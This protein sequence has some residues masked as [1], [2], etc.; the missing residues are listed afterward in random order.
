M[1]PL[2]I[3]SIQTHGDMNDGY[4]SWASS[5]LEVQHN[6]DNNNNN[7]N[8]NNNEEENGNERMVQVL[9][10]QAKQKFLQLHDGHDE[11]LAQLLLA[12]GPALKSDLSVSIVRAL[13]TIRGALMGVSVSSK[14]LKVETLDLL[15]GYLLAQCECESA[16][17]SSVSA[18]VGPVDGAVSDIVISAVECVEALLLCCKSVMENFEIVEVLRIACDGVRG[19]G[20]SSLMRV[21]R[22]A[23]YSLLQKA[24]DVFVHL[25]KNRNIENMPPTDEEYLR[26]F[27]SFCASSLMGEKDPR[28]LLSALRLLQQCLAKFPSR[29]IPHREFFERASIYYPISFYPPPNDPHKITREDLQVCLRQVICA[30]SMPISLPFTLFIQHLFDEFDED[31]GED[32]EKSCD[33][34][35]EIIEDATNL[36]KFD[37]INKATDLNEGHPSLSRSDIDKFSSALIRA[38][39]WS[40]EIAPSQHLEEKTNEG[41]EGFSSALRLSHKCLSVASQVSSMLDRKSDLWDAFCSSPIRVLSRRCGEM[42]ES[43][44]G[45]SASRYLC[46]LACSTAAAHQRCVQELSPQLLNIIRSAATA[47]SERSRDTDFER[48]IAALISFKALM[49]LKTQSSV[50]FYP[51]Y[52][53]VYSDEALPILTRIAMDI[54]AQLENEI[55][56]RLLD[57]AATSLNTIISIYEHVSD[58]SAIGS[59]SKCILN[60]ICPARIVPLSLKKYFDAN[61]RFVSY[62]VLKNNNDPIS[63]SLSCLLKSASIG[64]DVEVRY[65]VSTLVLCCRSS[66]DIASNVVWFFVRELTV[67]LTDWFKNPEDAESLNCFTLAKSLRNVVLNGG[68]HA[69]DAWKMQSA[70]SHIFKCV[71]TLLENK[72]LS[73]CQRRFLKDISKSLE[74]CYFI[75]SSKC[76]LHIIRQISPIIPPLSDTDYVRL[77]YSLPI[78][79]HCVST[80]LSATDNGD[81]IVELHQMLP[82]LCEFSLNA[83]V[84]EISRSSSSA[85]IHSIILG[86]DSL[87][88]RVQ[89]LTGESICPVVYESAIK[90]DFVTFEESLRVLAVIV[91]A[92]RWFQHYFGIHRFFR[93]YEGICMFAP[94]WPRVF[95]ML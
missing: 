46:A 33:I 35:F 22:S 52:L 58:N 67:K 50:R 26:S 41:R 17:S 76:R 43:L 12:L 39:E 65:D 20:I 40:F 8:N 90:Q 64:S 95:I 38:H 78:L 42:P 88:L 61:S 18:S 9:C 6:N 13:G 75:V 32:N 83:D 15:E 93:I 3:T 85:I 29:V 45:R 11:E 72:M 34:K 5:C 51:D 69:A 77:Q 80:S 79:A 37:S 60:N 53:V 48:V 62:F 74:S 2:T 7:N 4:R 71:W 23:C 68:I 82:S 47:R 57:M 91:S 94:W 54:N 10:Q 66:H 28:C 63:P 87:N 73:E 16:S 14:A 25:K 89:K 56:H 30:P 92:R 27:A 84:D 81:A 86:R 70:S 49:Q 31:D 36:V 59:L 21:G 44:R 1:D 19:A 55:D 24:L